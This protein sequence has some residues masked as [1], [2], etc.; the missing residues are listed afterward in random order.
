MIIETLQYSWGQEEN[1]SVYL[2]KMT[3]ILQKEV[4]LKKELV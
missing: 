2:V 1:K 4:Q 3:F